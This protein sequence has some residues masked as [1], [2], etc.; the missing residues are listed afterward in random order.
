[1]AAQ[2]DVADSRRGADR[3]DAERQWAAGWR[4]FSRT[5]SYYDSFPWISQ[6][7]KRL[8][9]NGT[10]ARLPIDLARSLSQSTGAKTR[11]T[12]ALGWRRYVPLEECGSNFRFLP[13]RT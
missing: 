1:M 7:Q 10:G 4:H 9:R 13:D 8:D 11:W 5:I 6:K 3:F 2:S 12:A